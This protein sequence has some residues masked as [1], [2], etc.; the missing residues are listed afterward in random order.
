MVVEFHSMFIS[1][2]KIT[3]ITTIF[4]VV[5][6]YA[7]VRYHIF[8]GVG[9]E[10]FPLFIS[11]KAISLSAVVFIA[12]SYVL[13]SLSRFWPH[14][15]SPTL[16]TRKLFGLLGF[17]LAAL[18][19]L[20]SLII[21]SPAHYPKFFLESG[22]INLV[23][24]LSMLFGILSFFIFTIV[25]L[26]SVPVIAKS[27]DQKHWLAI[28]R[29]GYLGLVLVFFHVLSMGLEGWLKPEGWPGGLLPISMVAAIVIAVVLLLKITAT[30]FSKETNAMKT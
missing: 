14:T 18:H 27:M 5:F 23:G 19:G 9:W 28:Q 13:G 25:A 12:I 22:K 3:I 8:K 29:F 4:I 21:F 7:I 1:R 6:A 16:G 17:S 2:S 26:A 11:N 15:F 30:I 20:I 24:E 10:E